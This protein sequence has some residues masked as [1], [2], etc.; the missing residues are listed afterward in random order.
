[1][2][3]YFGLVAGAVA[4]AGILWLQEPAR[5][6]EGEGAA[7][8]SKGTSVTAATLLMVARNKPTV[9]SGSRASESEAEWDSFKRTQLALIK[10]LYVLNAALRDEKVAKLPII[11]E[12]ADPIDFLEKN[13][14]CDFPAPE[15]MRI[16]MTGENGKDLLLIVDAVT[17][18]YL[19]EIVYKENEAKQRR[20]N[21]LREIFADH[22]LI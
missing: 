17:E 15:L 8:S 12:Q 21:K 14:R 1:M 16:A 9:M 13:I 4:M 2:A 20:I 5:S 3:F 22:D 6:Q 10:T 7:K 19:G 11:K 18:A